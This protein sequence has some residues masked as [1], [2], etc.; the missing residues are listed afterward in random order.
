MKGIKKW[1]T[2]L[3]ACGLL[4]TGFSA[5]AQAAPSNDKDCG[6]FGGDT[7]AV[8]EFWYNNGYSAS[9][10][11]HDLDRDNDGAPCEVPTDEYNSFVEKK[12]EEASKEEEAT[13]SDEATE[14][15]STQPAK[16]EKSDDSEEQATTT[17]TAND[18][19]QKGEEL[20]ETSSND[21]SMLVVA[22]VMAAIGGTLLFRR[23]KS[24]A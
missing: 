17:N 3:M 10:D 9:N 15:E 22:G 19:D 12:K 24:K 8:M 14:E 16:E 5:T 21:V 6:D 20:P 1:C 23:K 18:D 13:S 4:F 7:N 2:C 11:P